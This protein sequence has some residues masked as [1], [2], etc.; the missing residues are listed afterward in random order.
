[1]KKR[2]RCIFGLTH[3]PPK[4]YGDGAPYL[5]IKAVSIDGMNLKHAR[6]YGECERC[7]EEYWI[8]S[9]HLPADEKL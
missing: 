4:G 2:L 5:K 9:V 7:G 1:M 6:L 3:V 8:A